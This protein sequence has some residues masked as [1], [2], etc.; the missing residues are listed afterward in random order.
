MSFRHDDYPVELC[1]HPE[2]RVEFVRDE[3]RCR[4]IGRCT[5]CGCG[6]SVG[7]TGPAIIRTDEAIASGEVPMVP[8]VDQFLAR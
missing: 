7:A 1:T 3:Q 8:L 4:W 6:P 5:K 2:H